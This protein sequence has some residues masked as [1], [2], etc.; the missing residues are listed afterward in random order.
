MPVEPPFP[1]HNAKVEV[2]NTDGTS[3]EPRDAFGETTEMAHLRYFVTI[4][5]MNLDGTW[6]W[7]HGRVSPFD[8]PLCKSLQG[9]QGQQGPLAPFIYWEHLLRAYQS[10]CR[11]QHLGCL[12]T[13]SESSEL[14]RTFGVWLRLGYSRLETPK[15]KACTSGLIYA[16]RHHQGCL[17][18]VKICAF[19]SLNKQCNPTK[20][21]CRGDIEEGR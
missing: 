4:L 1:S 6:K 21:C 7:R 14:L 13:R 3:D 5:A 17:Q 9:Q 20:L 8:V 16:N 2:N 18:C 10:M 19:T 11:I 12:R 15:W